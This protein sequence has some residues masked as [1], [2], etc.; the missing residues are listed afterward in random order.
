MARGTDAVAPDD[1]GHAVKLGAGQVGVV[2][3]HRGRQPGGESP[4]AI[5][6]RQERTGEQV[7][8]SG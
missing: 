5:D 6:H 4:R 7:S 8:P 2:L 1:G 3:L